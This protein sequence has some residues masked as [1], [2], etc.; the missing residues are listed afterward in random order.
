MQRPVA[1]PAETVDRCTTSDWLPNGGLN[2][3]HRISLTVSGLLVPP[4]GMPR[5]RR[6]ISAHMRNSTT[7]SRSGRPGSPPTKSCARRSAIRPTDRPHA[8]LSRSSIVLW[9]TTYLGDALGA[10]RDDGYP[11]S[12]DAL[13]H[14]TPAQHDHINFYGSYDFDIEPSARRLGRRPL[15]TPS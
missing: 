10:L 9:N 14:L 8:R 1:R 13:V 6:I 11:I 2:L 15:R 7:A 4:P 3:S 12:D 5:P